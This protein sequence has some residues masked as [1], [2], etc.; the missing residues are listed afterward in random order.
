MSSLFR[1]FALSSTLIGSAAIADVPRT[2]P[3]QALQQLKSQLGNYRSVTWATDHGY[4]Q[5][6]GCESHP[7][8]GTMGYH[9]ARPDLLVTLGGLAETYASGAGSIPVERFSDA[10]A[11]T[12]IAERVTAGDLVFVK[13][14]RGVTAEICV[15]AILARGGEVTDGPQGGA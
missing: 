3:D 5:A 1:A 13:A 14:S 10:R 2:Q 11:A 8:L 15:D 7:T 12:A 6:S 4:V 9:Y